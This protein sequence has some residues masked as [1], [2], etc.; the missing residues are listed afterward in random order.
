MHQPLCGRNKKNI[1]LIESTTGTAIYMPPSFSPVF[2]YC[3]PEAK[4]RD[5]SQIIITGM[6]PAQIEMAK[7]KMHEQLSR[8][9]LFVKDVEIP[10][11]KIDSILLSRMDKLQKISEALGT[12]MSFPPLG[13]RQGTVR[14]QGLENLHIER[15]AREL[16]ALVS[17][18]A[19]GIP[20][21]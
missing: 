11:E 7:K 20:F 15:T 6:D 12:H 2:R 19:M 21:P 18:A 17:H 4:P 13:S 14:I 10:P 9:R 8:L 5:H 1:K 16:M 3:P